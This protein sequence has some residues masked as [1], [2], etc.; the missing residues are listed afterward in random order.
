LTVGSNIFKKDAT[1]DEMNT[2]MHKLGQPV[3]APTDIDVRISARPMVIGSATP[4][5]DTLVSVS[6]VTINLTSYAMAPTHMIGSMFDEVYTGTNNSWNNNNYEYVMFRDNPLSPETYVGRILGYNKSIP[7]GEFALLV[8]LGT[9]ELINKGSDGILKVGGS[10]IQD[11]T[12]TGYYTIVAD[13]SKMTYSIKPYDA[14]GAATYTGMEMTGASTGTVTLTQAHYNPHIWTADNVSLKTT[15]KIQFHAT[16]GGPVWGSETFPWGTGIKDGGN[17]SVA[18]A[19]NYFV[20]FND[21]T[22]HYV[23]FK[24]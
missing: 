3:N 22:G 1:S 6:K 15:D 14:S 24:K 20:K 18:P 13:M 2:I 19:G 16:S 17:I 11:I 8:K 4:K 12:T 9:W 21:L 5:L 23:F 10:N 7:Y